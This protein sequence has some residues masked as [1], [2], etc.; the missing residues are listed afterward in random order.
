MPQHLKATG[1]EGSCHEDS[2]SV[3]V[4]VL[5]R[6]VEIAGELHK[7]IEVGEAESW[8]WVPIVLNRSDEFRKRCAWNCVQSHEPQ[9]A[10]S[11]AAVWN[12]TR[13]C[14]MDCILL[15][16]IQQ[17][18]PTIRWVPQNHHHLP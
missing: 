8:N 3:V 17:T 9:E 10:A 2:N 14:V 13:K 12:I 11:D 1:R 18:V 16:F 4:V 6:S 15:F 7:D 5:T